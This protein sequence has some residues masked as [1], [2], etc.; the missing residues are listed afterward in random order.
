MMSDT[1]VSQ[2]FNY[3]ALLPEV[4]DAARAAADR[5]RDR[6]KRQMEALIET[7]RDL[8]EMKERLGHGWF[9][10]WLHAEFAWTDRTARNF[11]S[12]AQ[13]FADKTEII[14]DLPPT[15]LYLLAAPSTPS[16]V[17][18]TVVS[19]L[20]EGGRIEPA[21]VRALVRDA[22]EDARRVKAEEQLSPQQRKKK[23]K[24]RAEQQTEQERVMQECRVR[25][26][27]SKQA[28]AEVADFIVCQLGDALQDVIRQI[29][30]AKSKGAYLADI[31]SLLE[32]KLLESKLLESKVD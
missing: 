14:S 18:D 10:A 26:E 4:A 6:R 12:A 21:E 23:A 5:I 9:Q 25:R 20:K 1:L 7:G 29:E 13:Q 27:A 22:K 19:R 8:L 31:I 11:M 15:E 28:A 2:E 32:S 30:V 17:R 24:K 3:S 16:S